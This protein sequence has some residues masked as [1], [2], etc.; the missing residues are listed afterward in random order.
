MTGDDATL[1]VVDALEELGI[2]YMVVGSFSS[3]VYGVPRSTH[4]VDFVIQLGNQSI[5]A[6]AD[7]LGASFR[8][9]PPMSFE[10][11]TMTT[12]HILR[13]VGIP[14]RIELFHLS[15]DPHDQE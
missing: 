12:R 15:D 6:L 14:F 10:T 5:Q 8:L 11:V 9:D 1:A 7:R 13:V 2:P 4:D 3:N